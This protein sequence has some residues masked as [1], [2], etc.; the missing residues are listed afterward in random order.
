M[1]ALLFGE[2]KRCDERIGVAF[3]P[4]DNAGVRLT[5]LNRRLNQRVEHRL[6]IEG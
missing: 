2:T 4:T 6:Q 3:A 5:Q 1:I